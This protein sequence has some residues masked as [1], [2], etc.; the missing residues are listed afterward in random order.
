MV[1]FAPASDINTIQKNREAL[2]VAGEEIGV[3]VHGCEAWSLTM[4]E[5]VRLRMF[6]SRVLKTIF[7]TKKSEATGEWRKLHDNELCDLYSSPNTF[8]LIKT[9]RIRCA[10]H[11]ACMGDM[12]GAYRV[13]VGRPKG[14]TRCPWDD[15]IKLD[16]QWLGWGAWTGLIWLR[17]GT[18]GWLL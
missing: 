10:G 1:T 2:V 12:R 15:N 13:S 11:V 14:K 16:L 7:R 17:T 5:E 9:R 4:R 3:E 8:R 6:E 18:D